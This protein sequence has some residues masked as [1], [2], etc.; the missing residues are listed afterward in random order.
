MLQWLQS[1]LASI[2]ILIGLF[3]IVAVIC[4][5]MRRDKKQGKHVCGGSC[6][7]CGACSGCNGCCDA[8]ANKKNP[9]ISSS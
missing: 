3:L 1:N 5:V 7:S 4:A 8:E 2:L 6:G 9:P